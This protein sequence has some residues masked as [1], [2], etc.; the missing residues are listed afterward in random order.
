MDESVTEKKAETPQRFQ[1]SRNGTRLNKAFRNGLGIN[2][3]RNPEGSPITVAAFY[4]SDCDLVS[5]R[6]LDT[7]EAN[8]GAVTPFNIQPL[9]AGACA[10]R[11]ILFGDGDTIVI[12]DDGDRVRVVRHADDK[13]DPTTA[14]LWALG[15]KVFGKE[16][17]RQISR[18]IRYRG[19]SVDGLRREKSERKAMDRAAKAA[20]LKTVNG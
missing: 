19:A 4:N 7:S 10:V 3:R 8:G 14:V 6:T 1:K 2:S 13:D 20:M 15:E 18:A 5:V 11:R 16:L 9:Y 12:F 17:P